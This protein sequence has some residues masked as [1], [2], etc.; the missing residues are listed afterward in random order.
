MRGWRH[1]LTGAALAGALAVPALGA[2]PATASTTVRNCVPS[3][4]TVTHGT[5]QGAAGTFYY[6]I[7][8]TNHGPACAIWGAPAI[9][10]VRGSAHTPVGPLARNESMGQMPVRHVLPTGKSVSSSFGVGDTGN[11]PPA[12]CLARHADGVVVTLGSFVRAAYVKLPISVCTKRVSV[13]TQLVKPGV[14]G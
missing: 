14:N 1:V 10:P 4:I 2:G 8:F 3:A 6:P 5:S 11:Y 9:Q 13:F 7:V 12:R